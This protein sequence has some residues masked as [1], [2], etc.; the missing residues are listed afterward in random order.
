MSA[1]GQ[2]Q[3]YA[4]Q[5]ALSA[6]PPIATAKADICAAKRHVHFAPIAEVQG[7]LIDSSCG[8]KVNGMRRQYAKRKGVSPCE[9][10]AQKSEQP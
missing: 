8:N 2:K 4:V 3:T 7:A 1:L 9:N 10:A 6:L 5:K